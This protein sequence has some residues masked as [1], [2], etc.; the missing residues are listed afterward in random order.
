MAT[1]RDRLL[2]QLGIT[3]WALHRP[4]VLQGEVAVSLPSHIRFL[5]VADPLPA[6][7]DP[8]I[9]DVLRS[10][11]VTAQQVYCLMPDQVP[12]LPSDTHCHS[13][14]LGSNE[15]LPVAGTQLFSPALPE[16]YQNASAKRA[17]WQQICEN[18]QDLYPDA[19]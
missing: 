14:R 19:R 8:L 7:E 1:R 11:D 17:L 9:N 4:S 3:Q 5:I 10:L 15:P 13:W 12:M 2:Q 6:Q 18:E 16:L